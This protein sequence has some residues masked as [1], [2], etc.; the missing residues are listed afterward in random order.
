MTTLGLMCSRDLSWFVKVIKSKTDPWDSLTDACYG[1]WKFLW[2]VIGYHN[3][4]IYDE[5]QTQSA[6]VLTL[7]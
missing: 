5:C 7:P 4:P 6:W 3:S 2:S 1:H